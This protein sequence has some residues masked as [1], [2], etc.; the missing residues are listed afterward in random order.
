MQATSKA[1][2]QLK[3]CDFEI[4]TF[5]NDKQYNALPYYQDKIFQNHIKKI[6]H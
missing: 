4:P 3:L 6:Y 1:G 2:K 5:L